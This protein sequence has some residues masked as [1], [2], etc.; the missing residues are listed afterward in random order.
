MRAMLRPTL[1]VTALTLGAQA[2]A[3]AGQAV[4]AH[5]LGVS[6]EVDALFAA[7]TLPTY[8]TAVLVGALAVVFIPTFM[9][10]RAQSGEDA[11]WRYASGL[12]NL[13]FLGLGGVAAVGMIFA[14]PLTVA[15]AP[16]LAPDATDLAARL[17]LLAWPSVVASGLVALLT[18]LHQVEGRFG[19]SS[20]V[21]FLGAV[22]NVLLLVVLV[23]PFGVAGVAAAFTL[24][25]G[26]QAALLACVLARGRY[27][28]SLA[29]HD[30]G[31]KASARMVAPLV[32]SG[33]VVRVTVVID[34][35]L[36]SNLPEGSIAHLGYAFRVVS[37]LGVGVSTGLGAV[38]FPALADAIA[39]RDMERFRETASASLR[40]IWLVVAPIVTV[41][42]A[43]A[44]GGVRL[45]FERG[46]FTS[47]DSRA[48]AL[49]LRIY[50]VAIVAIALSVVTSRAM[51]ALKA[52]RLLAV[53][54]A[55]E[56]I[57]YVVYT[58]AF[59]QM[60][61]TVGIA[62]AFVVYYTF[63]IAWQ[64]VYLRH[65][66]GAGGGH[67]VARSL[68]AT[69]LMALLAGAAAWLAAL[70]FGSPLLRVLIGGVAGLGIYLLAV[71][72]TKPAEANALWRRLR[73]PPSAPSP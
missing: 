58:Y 5:Y 31:V 10:R 60:W 70:P 69:T 22:A 12:V 65:A 64:G 52:T 23:P 54:G 61:G 8:A 47:A 41:A 66:M 51:Y 39:R 11:A 57:A 48:V 37:A 14:E 63:S 3:L 55:V 30:P 9:E 46:A 29:L 24:N 17:A 68:A 59:A 73:D 2:V 53:V 40:T 15:V 13:T 67:R 27:A 25:I 72:T 56:A 43:L 38:L 26:L 35:F 34:R 21:P 6:A 36:A 45:V 4:V 28:F 1:I 49:L 7:L 20:S 33:L 18:S 71:W 62:F 44:D 19:W 32:L 42:I 50:L 16:G